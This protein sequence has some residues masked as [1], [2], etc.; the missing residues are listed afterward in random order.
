MYTR[1]LLLH[2][3]IHYRSFGIGECEFSAQESVNKFAYVY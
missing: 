2:E 3:A 1:I